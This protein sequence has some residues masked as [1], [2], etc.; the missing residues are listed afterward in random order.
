MTKDFFDDDVASE[1]SQVAADESGIASVHVSRM[2]RHKGELHN[3][4]AEAAQEMEQ[5]RL[6]QEELKRER[7]SLE[8]LSARQHDL[9]GHGP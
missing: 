4:A 1:S 2:V 8:E 7:D 9:Q 3:Q 5:L 6:R